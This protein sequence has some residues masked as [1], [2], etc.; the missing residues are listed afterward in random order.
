MLDE[1]EAIER[2][3]FPDPWS[4]RMLED[5]LRQ[6]GTVML[7][8]LAQDGRLA[9]YASMH[10]VLDEGYINNIAVAPAC[11]RQG[12]GSALLLALE[13]AAKK[14]RLSFLT[15][16]VRASNAAAQAL[17]AKHGFVPVGRRK[18]YYAQP[19][20]D[21]VLMTLSFPDCPLEVS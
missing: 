14:E 5:T 7:S 17:Y 3:C 6:S 9:G 15:L 20:E 16:E 1:V 18:N 2:Q 12:A 19:R 21:A 13:R 8:A 10:M 4:R 11:R